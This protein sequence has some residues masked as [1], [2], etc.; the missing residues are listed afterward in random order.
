MIEA[1]GL[2]SISEIGQSAP[3]VTLRPAAST[4]GPAVVAYIR[5]VGQRDSTFALEPGVGIYIDDVY[6]PTLHGSMI[7]LIDLDRVEILRGPQGT[8]A[9]QNSIGGAIRLYS[10]RPSANGGGYIQATYGSYNRVELRGAANLTLVPD[11]LWA[12]V[13]GT[14]AH[15]DGYVTRYDYA[16]T[17]PGTAI[18][19]FTTNRDCV[20]GTAG[21]KDYV[22]GRLA[23]RWEPTSR[24][25]V[26]LVG[27]VTEDSSE[28]GPETLLYVGTTT[29]TGS[30][31]TAPYTYNGVR[32]GT[33]TGSPFISSTPFGN[34]AQDTFSH[35]PYIN[36]ETYCDPAPR[37]GAAPW[38]APLRAE[39]DTWGVSGNVNIELSDAL[40]LVSITSYREF[41]GTYSSGDGSPLTPTLQ[42]SR[43]FNHQFS[44][45]VR[46]N[47]RIGSTVNFTLGGFY[48]HKRSENVT[49][50]TLPTLEF[51]EDNRIPSTTKAVFANVD[52][53]VVPGLDLIGG[54]RY[55]DVSKSFI[56]GRF[57][58]PGVNGGNPPASIAPLNGVVSTF[59]GDRFDYR[60]V[61]QYRFSPQFMAYA[62]YSTGFKSGGANARP[63]FPAQA[64]PH[65]PETL[66]AYEVGFKS[67]LFDNHLRVNVAGFWNAYNDILVTV[68]SCPLPGVPSAPCA[69]PINAGTARVRGAE[70]E[71]SARPIEGMLIDASLAYLDFDYRSLSAAAV[72]SG[73]TL[74][75]D[76]PYIQ[77]WQWSIGAQYTFDLG[78]FGTLTP[79]IDVN[80]EDGFNRNP[81]NSPFGFVAGRTL[82]NARLTLR[83]ADNDWQLSAEVKNLTDQVYYTDIF[84]NRGSTQSIQGRP[85]EPRTFAVTLRRNF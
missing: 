9:G 63:F 49:R 5:G 46:L 54:I 84:D 81:V 52:W 13:S 85:G 61:I 57:G 65:N 27:D 4:Y 64:L 14:G 73:I 26:D 62:Q 68:A 48:F 83:T 67:D 75:M 16:C 2:T 39:L 40:N 31:A 37:N 24:I 56:Y 25:S 51:I 12:R 72:S 44:E 33:A 11:H 74:A 1:R 66:D 69:L 20:L 15:R 36:Y 59:S 82:L 21:G 30:S 76:G 70:L 45:E 22:A 42:T 80:H 53:Q 8:L 47:G 79:R 28:V 77:R 32:F 60:G 34:Y 7:E 3:N 55:S 38:C 17:H 10:Q 6:L 41:D 58:I 29:A 19:S 35:S 50:V 23:V 78:T 43:V 18:P 71:L